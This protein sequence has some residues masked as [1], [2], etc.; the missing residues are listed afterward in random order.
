MQHLARLRLQRV[1]AE[2]LVLFLHMAEAVEDFVHLV[3]ALGILH[4][5]LEILQLMMQIAGA[6]A[7]R[8][9]FIQHRPALHLLHILAEIADGQLLRDRD[10]AFVGRFLADHHAEESRLAGAVGAHQ[11]D[12]FAGVQL[13]GSVDED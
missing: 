11:A 3:R 8:D 9:G 2:M 5:P 13:K 1:A 7:A 6:A 10:F 4:G 12:L